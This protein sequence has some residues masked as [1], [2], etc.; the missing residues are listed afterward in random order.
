MEVP[1]LHTP[2]ATPG[3][4]GPAAR[5]SLP[6]TAAASPAADPH[7]VQLSRYDGRLLLDRTVVPNNDGFADVDGEGQQSQQPPRLNHYLVSLSFL[8]ATAGY[9]AALLVLGLHYGWNAHRGQWGAAVSAQVH[10][11]QSMPVILSIRLLIV[12]QRLH[13]DCLLLRRCSCWLWHSCWSWS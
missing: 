3:Q 2:R 13:F 10:A 9:A 11:L 4:H 7:A 6:G 12:M 1:L 8:V 5:H